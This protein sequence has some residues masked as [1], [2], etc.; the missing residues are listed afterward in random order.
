VNTRRVNGAAGVINA[1]L[2][3]CRTA[4]GIALALESAQLLMT[5]E[6]AAEL[7]RYRA[8]ELG[9]TDGRVSAT[10]ADPG[11]PTWLRAA[12]DNRACP[13]CRVA[14]LEALT[15]ARHQT[16]RVCG[17]GYVF[18][19]PCTQCEFRARMAAEAQARVRRPYRV[20]HD[21]PGLGGQR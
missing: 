13:W 9:D 7:E 17:A 2:A 18:G 20:G 15:P 19:E 3:Q 5:P 16:C 6:T 8:M 14:E 10:C 1:A 21:L 12:S 4:A 11:H